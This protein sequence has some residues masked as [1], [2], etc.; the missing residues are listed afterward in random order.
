[1]K[2]ILSTAPLA[3]ILILSGLGCEEADD[4]P[5]GIKSDPCPAGQY[6]EGSTN[7]C[8]D[9]IEARVP[10][11]ASFRNEPFA[12]R[13]TAL[14]NF[15]TAYGTNELA[16]DSLAI[17]NVNCAQQVEYQPTFNGGT[18]DRYVS[19][20][21]EFEIRGTDNS[22]V[23]ILDNDL[24]TINATYLKVVQNT[25]DDSIKALLCTVAKKSSVASDDGT[26]YSVET[27]ADNITETTTSSCAPFGATPFLPSIAT[28]TSPES[29]KAM[30]YSISQYLRAART[31]YLV[32]DAD[33]TQTEYTTALNLD[34]AAQ[35]LAITCDSTSYALTVTMAPSG[36]TTVSGK[37]TITAMANSEA[38]FASTELS[39]AAGGTDSAGEPLVWVKQRA[40]LGCNKLDGC[41]SGN[42]SSDKA[43]THD[44]AFFG[45]MLVL[46]NGSSTEIFQEAG[47]NFTYAST[48]GAD[49]AVCD[50][51]YTAKE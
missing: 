43:I 15:L 23:L 33:T 19:L 12:T 3:S 18:Y 10:D 5:I 45:N 11:G 49:S 37:A 27:D 41:L 4:L 36:L 51:N 16:G 24:A 47:G 30:P 6:R 22:E 34:A 13:A 7:T 17:S 9:L 35:T 2:R 46:S 44:Y 1:M 28:A 42:D 39:D 32:T 14:E 26:A 31:S 38:F 40:F 25:S 8:L 29:V 50:F 48:S 21:C 20:N